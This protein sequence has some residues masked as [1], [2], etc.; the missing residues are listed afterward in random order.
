MAAGVELSERELVVVLVVED[1]E[2]GREEG[3]EVLRKGRSSVRTAAPP[4]PMLSICRVLTSMTGNW[5]RMASRR[6]SKAAWV[7]LTLRM[8]QRGRRAST[9]SRLISQRREVVLTRSSEYG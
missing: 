9:P 2:E 7:N 3:V 8:L 5:V 1:V 4:L 6:S